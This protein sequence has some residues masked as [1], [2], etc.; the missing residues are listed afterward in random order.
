MVG[1][2]VWFRGSMDEEVGAAESKG[3]MRMKDG[4][5]GS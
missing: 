3:E 1:E 2:A 5:G 4:R